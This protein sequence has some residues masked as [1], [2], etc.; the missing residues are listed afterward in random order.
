MLLAPLAAVTRASADT[1]DVAITANIDAP[2]RAASRLYVAR[3]EIGVRVQS[4][5]EGRIVSELQNARADDPDIVVATEQAIERLAASGALAPQTVARL[6]E[7]DVILIGAATGGLPYLESLGDIEVPSDPKAGAASIALPD[8]IDPT[9]DIARRLLEGAGVWYE[10]RPYALIVSDSRAALAAVESGAAA[11][12]FVPRAAARNSKEVRAVWSPDDPSAARITYS[13]AL[14]VRSQ[15]RP[16]AAELYRFLLS[17]TAR[18]LY[19][20]NGFDLAE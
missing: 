12:A 4:H 6:F 15:R 16:E 3:K 18:R 19:E 7:T 14:F 5:V 8:S 13:L 10:L 11:F 9:Y 1:L 17:P 20:S 2:M